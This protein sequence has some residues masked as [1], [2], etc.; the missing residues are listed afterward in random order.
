MNE[1]D[2]VSNIYAISL[3]TIHSRE[4]VLESFKNA[5]TH[6]HFRLLKIFDN[7]D[8]VGI[9]VDLLND[10]VKS[11]LNDGF[12]KI[13]T[14]YLK[15]KNI[16][17]FFCD[18]TNRYKDRK[19]N[20][21]SF[22]QNAINCN[23]G[24]PKA[25]TPFNTLDGING[26]YEI[27]RE[28][29]G[30]KFKKSITHLAGGLQNLDGMIVF[31]KL[32]CHNM[33]GCS[34]AIMSLGM[35]LAGKMGKTK[36]FSKTPPRVNESKCSYCR[37]CLHRCP[38]N[39]ITVDE[40]SRHAF[41]DKTKCINCG[42]CVDVSKFGSITYDW[43]A[44]P[45]HF[46]TQ[47]VENAVAATSMINTNKQLYINFLMEPE[48]LD[49]NQTKIDGFKGIL[50]SKDPLAIDKA[51]NDLIGNRCQFGELIFEYAHELKLGNLK[52]KIHHI[53]Y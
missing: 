20:F 46:Q 32:K 12:F 2:E 18:T 15:E 51:S 39:A 24:G 33:A 49:L 10:P 34:G 13:I 7:E 4:K 44:D 35:G 6:I 37:K 47:L 43:N 45:E 28:V 14:D 17:P 38:V 25:E 30:S 41:I 42:K 22:Y 5:L 27:A 11:Y 8:I 16:Y 3:D 40:I 52:Y 26:L 23:L 1:R 21:I 53:A 50:I 48:D 9:K 31:S 19:N 29:P 36:L